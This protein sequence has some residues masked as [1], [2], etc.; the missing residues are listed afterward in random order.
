ME[1]TK[2]VTVI[3]TTYGI[4]DKLPRAIESVLSQSYNHIELIVVDDNGNDSVFQKQTEKVM[5]KYEGKVCYIQHEKN[6][7]GSA[8]RN[9]GIN[10]SNGEYISFLDNDDVILP[11]RIRNS[12]AYLEEHPNYECIFTGVLIYNNGYFIDCVKDIDTKNLLE[13][14]LLGKATIGTGSNLFFT[15]HVVDTIGLFDERFTRFQDLEYII[16]VLNKFNACS[17]N[18]ILIIKEGGGHNISSYA[19]MKKNVDMYLEK[20][21]FIIDRLKNKRKIMEYHQAQ[22]LIYA[23]TFNGTAENIEQE[24]QKLETFRPLTKNERQKY[25]YYEIYRFFLRTKNFLIVQKVLLLLKRFENHLN[26]YDSYK[27]YLGYK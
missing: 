4:P 26:Q 19:Q 18:D 17:I 27:M 6:K 15:K 2:L 1:N 21:R 12:V 13:G 23:I 22:L 3:I 24:K 8:A 20:F 14:I 16:R 7:N 5:K 10:H 25:Q 9:T 11:D